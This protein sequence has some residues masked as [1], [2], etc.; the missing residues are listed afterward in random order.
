MGALLFTELLKEPRANT[1]E[2]L[3]LRVGLETYVSP[4]GF[5]ESAPIASEDDG[6]KAPPSAKELVLAEFH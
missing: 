4:A 6:A 2:R 3:R 1:L 5:V